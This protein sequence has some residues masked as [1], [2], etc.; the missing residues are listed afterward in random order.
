MKNEGRDISIALRE[1]FSA[2]GSVLKKVGILVGKFFYKYRFLWMRIG[3]ALVTLM[4]AMFLSF[5]LL[6]LMPADSV[7]QMAIK[8]ATERRIP[9]EEA[10]E[11]AISILGYDP[12][13]SVFEKFGSYVSNLFRG[14]LG[15][16]IVN[17]TINV[18]SVIAKT[19]PW[20]L[21]ISTVSLIISFGL[22]TLIG[23][24]MA[25]K[26]GKAG[27]AMLTSYIVVSS[28]IPDYIFA[29]IILYLF[30]YQLEWFP[31]MGAYSI[32]YEIGFNAEFIGSCIYHAILPIFANVF[33]QT[34][35]WALL[36]RGSSV[37]V[38]GEDYI[39][40]AR[41]RGVPQRTIIR[42]YMRKNA[43]LPLIASLALSFAGLFGG[44]TL[45]ESIFNYPGLGQAFS[46]Y[47]A[48]RDY[49]MI[50]GILFFESAI[51]VIAN[52]IAD[53]MYSIIDPRI[54]RSE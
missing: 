19:L 10:R 3:I 43:I 45:M 11:L 12:D 21:F 52:L 48:Q 15:V 20:T 16:S 28:A 26:R 22:G 18:N 40:A 42:K 30:A 4:L 44:S 34:A 23:A 9:F 47:I 13:E 36:M 25:W 41:T 46:L 49:F 31:Q 37:A 32:E 51:L 1:S 8:L 29:V 35:G 14:N 7:D 50:V 54:R 24:F 38:M 53:S 39:W 6:E 33:I 2:A 5:L 17:P 27:D